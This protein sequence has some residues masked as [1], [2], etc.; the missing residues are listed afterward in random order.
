MNVKDGY[1]IDFIP[2]ESGQKNGDA[3]AIRIRKNYVDTIYVIDGGTK[4]TGE[5]LVEHIK[6]YYNTDT[7]DYVINTHPDIDHVSGLTVVA[8]KLEVKEIWMHKPW[9]HAR[10]IIDDIIDGRVTENSLANRLA[11]AL[12]QAK[13]LEEIANKKEIPIYEP[14]EGKQI[15]EFKVLSPSKNWYFE[16]LKHFNGVPKV[17]KKGTIMEALSKIGEIVK[18]IFEDWHI[19]TLS[20]DGSTSSQNESS[21]ILYG[22]ING[23]KEVLFTGDA[24][25]NGISKATDFAEK[26]EINLQDCTF[27]QIPHHGG[28]RNVSPK[29]LNKIIG[30]ILPENSPFNKTAFVNV[31]SGCEE[32]PKKSVTNAFIRRGVKVC[33]T[34]GKTICHRDGFETR[35]GW[36]NVEPVKFHNEVEE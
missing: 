22:N 21:V 9:E 33:V 29:I 36:S 28:R 1:E 35:E 13:K 6:E 11:E 12:K 34:K 23:N 14:F 30:E 24:G 27:I 8:E 18:T 4:D 17:E 7:V 2:V 26:S 16:L 32:H 19:E 5:K 10:K 25:L 15:G 20:E 3:I 31:S